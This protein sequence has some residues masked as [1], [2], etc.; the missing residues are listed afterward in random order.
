MVST[1]TDDF[2]EGKPQDLFYIFARQQ[3]NKHR[4]FYQVRENPQIKIDKWDLVLLMGTCWT[5]ERND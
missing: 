1:E 5:E 3:T 2:K 4:K